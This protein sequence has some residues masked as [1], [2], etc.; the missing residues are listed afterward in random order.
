MTAGFALAALLADDR[1]LACVEGALSETELP[2][3]RAQLTMALRAA[4]TPRN[5]ESGLRA[6]LTV[7]RPELEGSLALH[8]S[9]RMRALVARLVPRDQRKLLLSEIATRADFNLDEELLRALARIARSTAAEQA[10]G[11]A[12]A[13]RAES[14]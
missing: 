11:S 8:F 3:L 7:L 6:L 9:P 14:P 10:S 5:R 12:R 4:E 1:E 13:E 2:A